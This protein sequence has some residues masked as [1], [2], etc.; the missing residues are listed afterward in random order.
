L[1]IW[2]NFV[3]IYNSITIWPQVVKGLRTRGDME[4]LEHLRTLRWARSC[5]IPDASLASIGHLGTRRWLNDEAMAVLVYMLNVHLSE[6]KSCMLSCLGSNCIR[7]AWQ[8]FQSDGVWLRR[9]WIS[10]L[11]DEFKG[12]SLERLGLAVNVMVG[13]SPHK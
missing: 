8:S 11:Y 12:G 5:P 2:N 4:T 7:R 10:R 1:T 13:G 6:K 9:N 3:E